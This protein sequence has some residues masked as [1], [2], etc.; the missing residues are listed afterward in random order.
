MMVG[1]ASLVGRVR[2]RRTP[3]LLIGV[4]VLLPAVLLAALGVRTLAQDTHLAEAPGPRGH[5]PVSG[6]RWSL[7]FVAAPSA[8][9]PRGPRLVDVATGAVTTLAMAPEVMVQ[10]IAVSPTGKEIVY[11]GGSRAKDEGVWMLENFLPLAKPKAGS[12]KE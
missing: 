5:S 1:L 11:V 12:P 9:E 10:E 3:F 8:G 6:F 7:V 2:S 4:L